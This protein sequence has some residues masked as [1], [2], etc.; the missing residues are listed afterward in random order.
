MALGIDMDL[1]RSVINRTNYTILDV[2]SDVGGLESV[3]ASF[4]SFLLGALNYNNLNSQMISQ[5]FKFPGR[6][7]KGATE[8]VVYKSTMLGNA[9]DYILDSLPSCCVCCKKNRRQK[10]FEAALNR[11]QEETDI[12]KLIKQLRFVSKALEYVP[13]KK[14]KRKLV[15]ETDFIF[16]DLDPKT[17]EF[18]ELST[19]MLKPDLEAQNPDNV[20]NVESFR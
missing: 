1:T 6:G 20:L 9:L 10:Q 7:A 5:L 17:K 4:V 18:T 15:E 3:L 8:Q 2:L 11:L 19:I 13:L 12:I 16:L 14:D